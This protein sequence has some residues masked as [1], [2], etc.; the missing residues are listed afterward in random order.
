M[1]QNALPPKKY[2]VFKIVLGLVL[3]S[4]LIIFSLQ[5]STSTPLKLLWFQGNAPLVLLFLMFFGMGVLMGLLAVLPLRSASKRKSDLIKQLQ[6]RIE[7]LE[8]KLKNNY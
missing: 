6:E 3:L 2:P 8:E 5:N 1:T 7:L 4:L